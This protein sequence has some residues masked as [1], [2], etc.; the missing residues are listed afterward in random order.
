MK[1]NLISAI[2][3]WKSA[4]LLAL[5]AMVAAVAFSGVLT[6]TESA[7]AQAGGVNAVPGQT[8]TVAFDDI[9]QDRFR[10][11]SDSEGS[12]TFAHNGGQALRCAN[13]AANGCDVNDDTKPTTNPTTGISVRVA[14]DED[15]PIGEIYVQQVSRSGTGRC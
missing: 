15:S 2:A 4:A 9:I 7:D 8:V 14:V 5:V 1:N 10:I 13:G 6:S 11:D 3:G 12:A